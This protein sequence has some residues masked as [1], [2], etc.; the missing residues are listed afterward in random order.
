MDALPSSWRANKDTRPSS[1][2]SSPRVG[3]TLTRVIE[4][5]HHCVRHERRITRKSFNSSSTP[6]LIK[7][8]KMDRTQKYQKTALEIRCY[9][10]P[11]FDQNKAHNPKHLYIANFSSLFSFS[12]MLH[13]LESQ[14]RAHYFFFLLLFFLLLLLLLSFEPPP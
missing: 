14:G 11:L 13:V 6:A 2:F 1:S 4:D 5:R 9:V 7:I 8:K 10:F 3:L 12:L